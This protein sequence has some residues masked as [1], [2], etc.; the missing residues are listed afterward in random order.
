METSQKDKLMVLY[1]QVEEASQ[2]VKSM[3]SM[4]TG[5]IEDK[6]IED[7]N[8]HL[9]DVLKSTESAAMTILECA[10]AIGE[11]IGTPEVDTKLANAVNAHLTKILEAAG[12]Q[13]ISGQRIK[14]AINHLGT[15]EV[16]L[17]QLSK[18]A[19]QP[20]VEIKPKDALLNGPALSGEAPSQESIDQMFNAS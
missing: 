7:A 18:A 1:R 8:L 19:K 11:L 13:D 4:A 16:Q 9:S 6:Q 20:H 14:K 2:Y 12:F 3:R 5:I 15:L 17:Q 10:L